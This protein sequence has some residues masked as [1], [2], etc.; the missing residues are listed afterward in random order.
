MY[1]SLDSLSMESLPHPGRVPV[2]INS[3][4][5]LRQVL[6]NQSNFIKPVIGILN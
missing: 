2:L 3:L 5:S 4:E 1:A 6:E